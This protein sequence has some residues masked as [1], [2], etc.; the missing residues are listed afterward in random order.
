MDDY[1][2]RIERQI[3]RTY[4][5]FTAQTDKDLLTFVMKD[6]ETA[7]LSE[8]EQLV[9]YVNIISLYSGELELTNDYALIGDRKCIVVK[10]P[11]R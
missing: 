2:E 10:N 6:E 8:E 9:I 1:V 11:V 5:R 4:G 7:Q 3:P